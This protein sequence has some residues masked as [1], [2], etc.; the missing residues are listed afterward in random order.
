MSGTSRPFTVG[1]TGPRGFIA[2]HLARQLAL[3]STLRVLTCPREVFS[4]P[5]KLSE[6]ACECNTIVHLAGMNRGSEQ[7]VYNT[8]VSLVERL[9][10]TLSASNTTPHVIFASST[11]RDQ[12]T[13]YGRSKK[14]SESRLREWAKQTGARLTVLVIPD[15]FGPGCRP[16]YNSVIATF[17]EQLSHDQQPVVIDDQTLSLV[18]IYDLVEAISQIIRDPRSGVHEARVAG[19]AQFTVSELLA[20]L[21]AM[22][23]GYFDEH[24]VPN[25]ADPFEANLYTTFMS[26]VD[27]DDH[28]HRPQLHNDARGQL[29]EIMRLAGGGQIFFSTTK[30]GVIRGD[31]FHSRKVEWFCVVRGEAMIR[32]R[33]VGDTRVREFRVSGQKPEFISIPALHTHQIENVGSEDLLT[34]FWCNEIFQPSDPDTFHEKVA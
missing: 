5:E 22:R 15:V 8:N 28:C 18:W 9:I 30:P 3:D 21:Q 14:V 1:I 32:I 19:S 7:D 17:C 10:E 11:Q 16:Y 24:I 13:A 2:G 25:L 29:Y 23:D 31:H 12:A 4:Q 20:K 33:R 27:L 6:F 34:M 26:H